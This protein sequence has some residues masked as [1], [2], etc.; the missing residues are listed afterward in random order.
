MI[1]AVQ[2]DSGRGE[3]VSRAH[4]RAETVTASSA[5][6]PV[7]VVLVDVRAERLGVMRALL[8][9]SGMAAVVG[10]AED[11]DGAV[12]EVLRIGAD[13][14]I[15]EIQMPVPEGLAIIGALR[16][17]FPDLR[18]VVCSFDQAAESKR[19]ASEEGADAYL[20]KPLD[21]PALRALLRRFADTPRRPRLDEGVTAAQ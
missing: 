4:E 3:Q 19:R 10:A 11:R 6:E 18:I 12:E 15:V 17:R 2:H 13:L 21:L 20:S 7:L 1:L 9:A 8:Q 16:V 5:L 14:V